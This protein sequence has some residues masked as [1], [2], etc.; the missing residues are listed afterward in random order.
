MPRWLMIAVVTLLVYLIATKPDAVVAIARLIGG[1]GI[2][3]GD[4]FGEMISDLV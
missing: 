3:I 2:A 4:G 1:I